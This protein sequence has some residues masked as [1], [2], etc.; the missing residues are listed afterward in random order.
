MFVAYA[1]YNNPKMAVSVVIPYGN[2]SHDSA[3]L[4]KNVIQY[5]YGELTNEDI[6]KEVKKENTSDTTLD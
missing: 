5:Q 3:E 2:S 4:A 1:P 6:N